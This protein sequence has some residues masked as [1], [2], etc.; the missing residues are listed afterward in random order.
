[1]T[2]CAGLTCVDSG[3]YLFKQV[4][5]VFGVYEDELDVLGSKSLDILQEACDPALGESKIME[6]AARTH[7]ME[8]HG[9]NEGSAQM[10]HEVA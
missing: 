2:T 5:H 4:S 7:A 8:A 9:D 1:M 6:S 3:V 10:V